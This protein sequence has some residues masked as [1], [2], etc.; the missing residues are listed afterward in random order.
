M[1]KPKSQTIPLKKKAPV[2]EALQGLAQIRLALTGRK[3]QILKKKK[4]EW[5]SRTDH[6]EATAPL[7]EVQQQPQ[8]QEQ[9]L[10]QVREL[11]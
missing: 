10:G 9:E 8:Q 2:S 7:W 4:T 1:V 11:N 5:K 3:R 6:R